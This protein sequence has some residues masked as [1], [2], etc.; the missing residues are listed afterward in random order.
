VVARGNLEVVELQR[1]AWTE[2]V[3]KNKLLG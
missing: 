1:S 2:R 3:G